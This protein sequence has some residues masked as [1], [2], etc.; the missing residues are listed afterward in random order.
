MRDD[1]SGFVHYDD[2]MRRIWD[3]TYWH[4]KNFETRQP[5]EFVRAKNDPKAL[6][7]IRPEPDVVVPNNAPSGLVGES[8]VQTPTSPAG[9]IFKDAVGIGKMVIESTNSNTVFEVA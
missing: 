4:K 9:H 5:Q 7:H 3:G 2:Q 6:R 1:E 8:T